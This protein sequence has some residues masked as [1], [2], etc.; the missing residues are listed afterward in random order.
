MVST[1]AR[2]RLLAV[3][4]ALGLLAAPAMAAP[5]ARDAGLGD[6]RDGVVAVQYGYGYGHH[7]GWRRHHHHH[8]HGWGHRRHWGHHHGPRWGHHHH[9]RGHWGHRRHHHW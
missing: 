2:T 5:L 8:H 3:A 6:G 7:G 4:A 9:H 1:S